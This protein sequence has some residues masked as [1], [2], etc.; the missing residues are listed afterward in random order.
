MRDNYDYIFSGFGLSGMTL[1]MEMRKHHG[2]SDLDILVLD[3][4]TKIANDRT[5]SFWS[6]EDLE[7]LPLCA[8]SWKQ[9][10]IYRREGHKVPI[11]FND[12]TY[13]TVYGKD[14]Y[15]YVFDTI[16]SYDNVTFVHAEISSLESKTVTTADGTEYHG[17][18]I[19]NSAF[20]KSDIPTDKSDVFLWQ[21]FY[22]WFISFEEEIIDD[23]EFVMMDYRKCD[24]DKT[25]FF[26]QLPFSNTDVLIEFTEF[27]NG[28]YTEEEVT[29]R[30]KNYISDRYG[31]KKYKILHK[32]INAI[33]MTD[34]K[35]ELVRSDGVI[36][37]G[38]IAGYVKASSGYA[39]TRT[40]E[41]NKILAQKL[42]QGTPI[43]NR[44]SNAERVF[45]IFDRTLL[46]LMAN[47]IVHGYEVNPPLFE[48]QKGDF[49]IRFLQEKIP[50]FQLVKIVMP[51]P[52]KIHFVKAMFSLLIK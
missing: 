37:I 17:R 45:S 13:Y 43:S 28:E 40:I 5:W 48:N 36:N 24:P 31:D 21:H 4:S 3:K 50:L 44:S 2:F 18:N 1:L 30:I 52:K 42:M 12:Y 34:Y 41:K 51:M 32:E 11:T 15:R 29:P 8:K 49:V 39:F 20:D 9:S 19:I 46:R 22:G 38:T 35:R 33:P 27:S 25:N 16:S 14:F 10:S 47:N 26:Y 23:S 6:D 7:Y